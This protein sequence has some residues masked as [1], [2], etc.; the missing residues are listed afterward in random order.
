MI[1]EFYRMLVLCEL[2]DTFFQFDLLLLTAKDENVCVLIV[3]C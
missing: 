2:F 3:M 1:L